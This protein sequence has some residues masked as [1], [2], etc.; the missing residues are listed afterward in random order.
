[1]QERLN[2]AMSGLATDNDRDV[3]AAARAAADDFKR[4]AVRTSVGSVY[5]ADGGDG[6]FEALD[7]RLEAE[8]VDFGLAS[9][10]LER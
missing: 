7:R 8:E 6:D 4:V 3:A 1:M 2:S 5:A 10:E 9:D